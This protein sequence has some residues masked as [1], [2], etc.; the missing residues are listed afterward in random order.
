[1]MD[2]LLDQCGAPARENPGSDERAVRVLHPS[3]DF[4]DSGFTRAGAPAPHLNNEA[5]R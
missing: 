4:L 1:M 5:M 3:R 2:R